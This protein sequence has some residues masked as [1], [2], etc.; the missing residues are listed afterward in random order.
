MKLILFS[1]SLRR[2][3]L[4][5]KFLANADEI[6]RSISGVETL[7]ADLAELNFPVYNGDI[8]AQGIPQSVQKFS[9]QIQ[10]S[11]GIVIST[12]E[13][14]GGIASPV[15]NALDWVSRIKPM[16]WTG[17]PLL[18]MGASPG[19]LGAVRGLWHTR[20]PFEAAGTL[21]FPDMMGLPQANLAFVESSKLK[22]TQMKQRLMTLLQNYMSFVRKNSTTNL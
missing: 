16:P 5:R 4:N 19:A 17:K 6:L 18:L 3:S 22:D 20:V 9:K 11:D 2:E 12:P 10:E 14:N 1:G 7:V 13:Y 15:K 8:E 21:V